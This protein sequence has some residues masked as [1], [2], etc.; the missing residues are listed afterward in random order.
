MKGRLKR[1]EG[2][3]LKHIPFKESSDIVY[4]ITDRLGLLKAMAKGRRRPGSK[5]RNPL[6]LFNRVELVVYM[7]RGREIQL[8]KEASVIESIESYRISLNR[9]STI[10]VMAKVL[11][12]YLEINTPVSEIYDFFLKYWKLAGDAEEDALPLFAYSFL[13]KFMKFTGHA[14]RLLVCAK[15]GRKEDLTY[16]DVEEGGMVCQ[17]CRGEF[18][19]RLNGDERR[20]L[21]KL[22]FTEPQFLRNFS[23]PDNL[24]ELILNYFEY[25]TGVKLGE[26]SNERSLNSD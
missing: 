22:Y 12:H 26:V 25:H 8:I 6:E 17:N 3:V 18:S 2:I 15:C 10:S 1:T 14:P 21:K 4:I 11:I 7:E 19:I 20:A 9:L 16:F 13:F 5:L 24:R 23:L